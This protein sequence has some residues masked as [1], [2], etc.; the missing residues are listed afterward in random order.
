MSAG[1]P[2]PPRRADRARRVPRLPRTPPAA[3]SPAGARRAPSRGAPAHELEA[4]P[5][6]A[7][8]ARSS[9]GPDPPRLLARRT[10]GSSTACCDRVW[11]EL[12]AP[13]GVALVAVGGYGRGQ[14]FPH[15][16]VDVLILLPHAARPGRDRVR[17]A[18][19]SA[20]VGHRA[21]DRPQRAHDRRVRERGWP[22]TSPSARACSSTASS[23]ARGALHR[24]FAHAARDAAI[25][26]R[27][28]YE[29]KAAGAAAAPPQ[30]PR[31]RV[32]PRAQPQGKPRRAARP[33]DGAVDR[34]RRGPRPQ[35]ARAREGRAA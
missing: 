8:R 29:A 28:F 32:Q 20:A 19:L 34:A 11:R 12:G 10:R 33:A 26:V 22:P 31:H 5:R 1:T 3:R 30:V 16:D 14:L 13:P 4:R 9:R 21:R 18:L 24:A 23:R 35:L 25:D 27:A 7:A 2:A 17:R 6:G 15:S